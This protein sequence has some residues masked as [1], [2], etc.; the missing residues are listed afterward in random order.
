MLPAR[1]FAHVHRQQD[2]LARRAHF[3][4][5][6]R[7]KLKQR[8]FEPEEIGQALLRLESQGYLDDEQTAALWVKQQLAKKPQGTRRLLSGLRDR[9]IDS[10]LASR[11][12]DEALIDGEQA[13]AWQAAERKMARSGKVDEKALARHLD[14]LGFGAATVMRTLERA[15]AVDAEGS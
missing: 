12:V 4:A 9:G 15:R 14:R 3:S 7:N 5:E 10:E 8:G 6:L 1:A 13:T 11:T 2:L